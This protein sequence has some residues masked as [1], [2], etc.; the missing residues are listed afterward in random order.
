[1][2]AQCQSLMT[3]KCGNCLQAA[4]SDGE[5]M[6]FTGNEDITYEAIFSKDYQLYL[7]FNGLKDKTGPIEV[8]LGN[9]IEKP[10][11]PKITGY[12]FDDC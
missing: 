7:D 2:H 5:K 11:D 8:V 3:A 4:E 6:T 9:K 1:M 10:E 12:E